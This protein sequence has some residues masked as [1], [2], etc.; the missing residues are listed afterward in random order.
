M[1]DPDDHTLDAL[2]YLTG[3][4][5]SGKNEALMRAVLRA[6][7]PGHHVIL[8]PGGYRREIDVQGDVEV[9]QDALPAPGSTP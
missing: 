9:V 2:P 1:T 6:M 5:S 8:G 3:G 4:R 7:P